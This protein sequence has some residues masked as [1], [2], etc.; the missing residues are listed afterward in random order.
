M[1]PKLCVQQDRPSNCHSNRP[2]AGEDQLSL[3]CL[4]LSERKRI[5]NIVRREAG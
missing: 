5:S 3:N 2:A 1:M 4:A